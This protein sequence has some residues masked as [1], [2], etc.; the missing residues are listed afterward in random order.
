MNLFDW[1]MINYKD[2]PILNCLLLC[3]VS[4][5]VRMCFVWFNG[6][7]DC[8]KIILFFMG[9]GFLWV[10]KGSPFA[11]IEN[12]SMSLHMLILSS[13]CFL[14]PPFLLAGLP[15]KITQ[16]PSRGWSRVFLSLFA[17]LLFLYHIPFIQSLL[18]S[19]P[20][21][22]NLY[23]WGLFIFA[24]G[25]WIPL[26]SLGDGEKRSPLCLSY[27]TLSV[28]LILPSCIF[29]VLYS[30]FSTETDMFSNMLGI[31]MP[32][33]YRHFVPFPF[34]TKYDL[35]LSG[36]EMFIIHKMGM[37]GTELL[38]ACLSK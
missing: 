18:M 2:N 27:K 11:V 15:K 24:L 37:K 3:S 25:A 22:N 31:C 16:R 4:L 35:V 10:L 28:I 21:P 6:K 1:A 29:L 34:N 17:I 20:F 13:L 26:M 36:F 8:K 19:S 7:K 12:G 5:Y 23:E 32:K 9:L 14:V 38:L 33:D 30:F